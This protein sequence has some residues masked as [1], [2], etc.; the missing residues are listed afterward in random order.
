MKNEKVRYFFNG[1]AKKIRSYS[2]E[3]LI[4]AGISGMIS[5]T[6]MAVKS[7]PKAMTIIKEKKKELNKDELKSI[8]VVKA[9]FKCYIPSAVITILSVGCIIAASNIN[10]K[11]NAA[12]A[13]AYSLS[14]SALKLYQEKV[15]E[16]V[17]E[18]KE[19]QIRDEV[20]KEQIARNP[21]SKNEVIITSG[22][23][24]LCY[25]V[26][27]GRYYKSDIEKLRKAVNDLNHTMINSMCVT[28]NDYYDLIGLSS[29]PTGDKLGWNAN[30]ALV[31]LEF[32]TQ[33]ADEGV[34]CLVVDFR[35]RPKYDYER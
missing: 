35:T 27:S 2:P 13:T 22:G 21:V 18:K 1:I 10:H 17:G 12:L 20:A 19:Q 34:P 29:I 26:L 30:N 6:V 31:E 7:T 14:E 33:M 24:T 23:N 32:S 8:E 28:L 16:T 3:I 15:I 25:D 9:T 5:S 11:R 4:G